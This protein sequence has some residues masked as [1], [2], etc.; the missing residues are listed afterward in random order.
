MSVMPDP[1][2]K[3]INATMGRRAFTQCLLGSAWLLMSCSAVA[4]SPRR[5]DAANF[6]VAPG[7]DPRRND[8]GVRTALAELRRSGGGVLSFAP[9]RYRFSLATPWELPPAVGIAGAGK[10]VTTFERADNDPCNWIDSRDHA[11]DHSFSGFTAIG[12]GRATVNGNGAFFLGST[13]PAAERPLRDIRFS[14]VEL[15]NF[16]GD[17]WIF[18]LVAARARHGIESVAIDGECSFISSPGNAR[19]PTV[20][21]IWS[22]AII[23]QGSI[24]QKG[25]G[26]VIRDV[27]VG[28][29]TADIAHIKSLCVIWGAVEGARITRP[30]IE[31][32]GT[33]GIGDDSGAYALVV[34]N[35][36][37]GAANPDRIEIVGPVIRS[38]RSVGLYLVSWGGDGGSV[39]FDGTGGLIANVTD[40]ANGSLPKGAIAATVGATSITIRNLR[41]SNC[42]AA[43]DLALGPGTNLLVDG[44]EAEGVPANQSGIRIARH[45]GGYEPDRVSRIALRNLRIRSSAPG[46]TG[47]KFASSR[48]LGAVELGGTLE[49]DVPFIGISAYREDGRGDAAPFE[50]F[51]WQGAATIRNALAGA[52]VLRNNIS[53]LSIDADIRI[54]RGDSPG[55]RDHRFKADGARNL[56]VN[57]SILIEDLRAGDNQAW[58][59]RMGNRPGRAYVRPGSI[60]VQGPAR[61]HALPGSIGAPSN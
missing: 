48:S 60:S 13:T 8:Q 15:R 29:V 19:G 51:T 36:T 23:F 30:R 35:E 52:V 53:P 16:G 45:I 22:S 39:S 14:S 33:S 12:N 40:T 2:F 38:C 50:S 21:S 4:Q 47:L 20:R 46:V 42:V 41:T 26:G 56:R 27:S 24:D 49:I 55:P 54:Q 61:L 11:G 43:L 44:V 57:G 7:A 32:C 17:G 59:A 25:Q 9:G 34:G 18:F 37:L 6:G 10:A 1:D 31:R 3:P 28:P 5:L 58:E